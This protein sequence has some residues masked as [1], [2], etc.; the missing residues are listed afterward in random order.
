M[1]QLH[2][3]VR[4][5]ELYAI[6]YEE[7]ERAI[8]AVICQY[9]LRGWN[10]EEF[11]QE[12][13][14]Y[15]LRHAPGIVARFREESSLDTYF[16]TVVKNRFLN[17]QSSY[18]RRKLV[19]LPDNF[20]RSQFTTTSDSTSFDDANDAMA[21]DGILRSLRTAVAALAWDQRVILSLRFDQA[22]DVGAVAS[23]MRI[24]RKAASNRLSRATRALRAELIG[25]G[26]ADADVKTALEYLR[27]HGV[28]PPCKL[29]VFRK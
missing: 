6:H 2:D 11:G 16:T 3:T 19:P 20:A 17:W 5:A 15:V 27:E 24:T 7:I 8:A 14:L 21:T 22:L 1:A 25:H 23:E 28:P 13:R 12:A 4:A 29:R 9:R 10:A 26:V 18:R